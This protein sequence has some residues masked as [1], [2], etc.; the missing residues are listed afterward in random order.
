MKYVFNIA[1]IFLFFISNGFAADGQI[2]IKWNSVEGLERLQKAEYKNDFY[3]L[4]DYFQ[5]QINPLYCSVASSVIIL[6]AIATH[7]KAPSQKDL[8]VTKPKA[9]DGGNIPFKTYSQLTFFNDQTDK[10]KDRK[11][12]NL[13]NITPENENDAKN[14]DPGLT[15][16]ELEKILIK[17]YD[18]KVEKIYADNSD[19]ELIDKFRN[20][21]K[22][23][24]SDNNHYL[25]ANFSAKQLGYGWGGHISP[26]VAFDTSTDSILVMDVSGH[27]IGWYWVAIENFVKAMNTKDGNNYRGYLII[28]K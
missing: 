12:I 28:S 18:L 7:N 13:K 10:I 24:V 26:I 19:K 22:N 17:V 27:S 20:L 8:E 16:S 23:I 3:E 9:F 21:V 5:P 2:T 4:A 6:N 25:I 14:F 15:L 11:I 1:F